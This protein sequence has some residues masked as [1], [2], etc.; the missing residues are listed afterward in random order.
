MV[1]ENGNAA[2]PIEPLYGSMPP[3]ASHSCCSSAPLQKDIRSRLCVARPPIAANGTR[4]D[5][6]H[7][8]L[9][10]LTGVDYPVDPDESSSYGSIGNLY[11]E[12][13]IVSRRI[14][15]GWFFIIGGAAI[16]I[17]FFL[18]WYQAGFE[19]DYRGLFR[20]F[21]GMKPWYFDYD[22][23]MFLTLLGL[24]LMAYGGFEVWLGRLDS[25]QKKR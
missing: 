8:A 13:S 9:R 23:P 2:L 21:T 15:L 17:A 5:F 16:F 3:C 6:T 7:V 18:Q 10:R 12:G 25:K 22:N 19:F 24:I 4:S 11:K 1:Y 14:L 20:I